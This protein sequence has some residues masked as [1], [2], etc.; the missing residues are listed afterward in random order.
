MARRAP[1]GTSQIVLG[2]DGMGKNAAAMTSSNAFATGSNQNCGNFMTGRS[3]TGLHAPPGGHS[4]ICLGADDSAGA[5]RKTSSNAFAKGSNQNCGNFISERSS[6]GLHAPPGGRSSLQLGG[7]PID[8]R[9]VAVP[10]YDCPIW[11]NQDCGNFPAN[12]PSNGLHATPS[13]NA[14]QLREDKVNGREGTISSN[15]FAQGSNQ[16]CGNFLTDRPSTG[17]HAPPGGKSS[18]CLGEDSMEAPWRANQNRSGNTIRGAGV[19]ESKPT[20]SSN[21]FATGSNQNCGNVI[22]DRS[23]TRLHAPPGGHSSF[24]LG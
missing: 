14:M 7:D 15:A 20:T 19:P 3:S 13:G 21:R 24:V 6:T 9:K 1:G 8:V 17:L 22:T 5:P 23:S 2:D 4:S 10:T 18:L 12:S 11:S 16:N